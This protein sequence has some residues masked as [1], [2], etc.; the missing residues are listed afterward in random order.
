MIDEFRQRIDAAYAG[1]GTSHG[2]TPAAFFDLMDEAIEFRTVLE[3]AFPQDPLSGPFLGKVS[4]IGYWTAIAESW[5]LVTSRTEALV[6]EADRVVWYG[7][8]HWRNRRTLRE[9]TS[10]KVDVWTV[11]QGRAVRYFEMFDTAAY[12]LAAGI[13]DPSAEA[14]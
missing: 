5:D 3:R 14:A 8:I 10:P 11:W 6:A 9:F 2:T 1:W 4:V 12:A 7:Q 13:A